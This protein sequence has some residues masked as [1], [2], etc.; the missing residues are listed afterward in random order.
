M[1][2]ELDYEPAFVE[3]AVRHALAGRPEARLFH[4]E[5]EQVYWVR[6]PEERAGLFA[7]LD[8]R[9]FARLKLGMPVEQALTE[10]PLIVAGVAR[11]A[12]GRPR[13]A[14]EAGAELLVRDGQAREQSAAGRVLRL[15]FDPA[16]LIEPEPLMAFLRRELEH[17]ADMLDPDFGYEPYLPQATGPGAS[18]IARERYRVLWDASVDGR[19]VRAGK[20]PPGVRAERLAEVSRA[21]ATLGATATQGASPTPLH[22][23]SPTPLEVFARFFDCPRPTHPAIV[24]QVMEAC[25]AGRA[26]A[27]VCPLCGFA[28][29]D[30]EPGELDHEA[31][32]E[33]RRDFPAWRPELGCCRQCADLYQATKLSAAGAAALPG[34]R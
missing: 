34:I 8:A 32:E 5:R 23:A 1:P 21:F 6:D 9:W 2:I 17:V 10:Q 28:A 7:A 16:R 29:T 24:A 18:R 12:V 33:I 15:L 22:E 3:R 27:S 26:A 30:L 13:R 25:A 14:E 31:L 20:L 4:R 11:C 19:L